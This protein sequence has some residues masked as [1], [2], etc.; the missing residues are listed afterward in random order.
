[1]GLGPGDS[2]SNVEMAGGQSGPLTSSSLGNLEPSSPR[3]PPSLGDLE[4]GFVPEAG[5]RQAPLQLQ[6][7]RLV[8]HGFSMSSRHRIGAAM[9]QELTRLFAEQGVPPAL[10][11]G[12]QMDRLDG[13]Q[14]DLPTQE[15]PRLVGVRIAR[16]IYRRLSDG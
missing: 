1:M 8:L 7:D 2:S 5:S 9:Q 3:N 11:Q 15:N 13:I 4:P 6:I 14:F 12:Q 16:A 10:T